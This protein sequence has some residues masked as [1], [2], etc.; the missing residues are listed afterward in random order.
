[1]VVRGV[2][3]DPLVAHDMG[4]T[5]EVGPIADI[6]L[7]CR[8]GLNIDFD[9][10]NPYLKCLALGDTLMGR[11]DH[12]YSGAVVSYLRDRSRLC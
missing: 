2:V 8:V 5:H 10:C 4:D 7:R 12:S 9:T 1:M 6:L 3:C 11:I